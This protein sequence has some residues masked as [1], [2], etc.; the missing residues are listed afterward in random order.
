MRRVLHDGVDAIEL[1][2]GDFQLALF[3]IELLP[4][5]PELT[6]ELVP[7]GRGAL[8]VTGRAPG[9]PAYRTDE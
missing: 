7:G 6:Q 5:R 4:Q 8:G 9:P 1:Q 2:A 3:G